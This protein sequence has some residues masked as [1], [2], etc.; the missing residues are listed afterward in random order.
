MRFLQ[1][2]AILLFASLASPAQ[3]FRNPSRV[4]TSTDPSSVVAGDINGDGLPD[5]LYGYDVFGNASLHPLLQSRGGAFIPAPVIALPATINAKCTLADLNADKKLDLICMGFGVV[6]TSVQVAV[7]LGN[8]DGTFGAPAIVTLPSGSAYSDLLPAAVGDINHDGHL[9]IILTDPDTNRILPLLGDGAGNLV[10]SPTVYSGSAALQITLADLNGDGNPD[11]VAQGIYGSVQ[12]YQG[13]GDGTFQTPTTFSSSYGVLADLDGDGHLDLVGG[14]AGV[15][16]VFHGN[17]D[18]TFAATPMATVDYT[19]GS[20]GV[21]KTGYGSYLGA[22]ACL[23]LNGDGI[24]DILARGYDGLTV[25]MGLPG[26]HFAKP[27]H[28]PVAQNFIGDVVFGS[29]QL[30][31]LNGDGHQD[32]VAIGPGGLFITYGQADGTF[33]SGSVYEAGYVVS[34]AT[35]A[36]LMKT[37]FLTWSQAETSSYS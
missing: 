7:L 11:M 2:A 14:T 3:N 24:P 26:L 21:N 6:Y 32:F 25:I 23:D 13:N 16:Q 5:L 8:G 20:G 35:L 27:V 28:Y 30:I 36:D 29:N 17:A 15:L 31:D 9:D 22:Y 12:I 19:D 10:V 4:F 34:H 33:I 1:F 18:G 37:A